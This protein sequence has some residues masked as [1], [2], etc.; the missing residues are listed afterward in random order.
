MCPCAGFVFALHDMP[1]QRL[2]EVIESMGAARI[3][4]LAELVQRRKEGKRSFGSFAITVDDGVGYNVRALAQLFL[5]RAWPATF[6]L[7]TQYLD[8]GEPM[9]FQWWRR[10]KPLLPHRKLELKSGALDLSRPGAIEALSRSMEQRWRRERPETHLPLISE[11]AD[12]AAREIGVARAELR[13]PAPIS[14][15]EVAELSR[16]DLIRFE[17]HGVSHTA[18]SALT[19]DELVFEMG[20]SQQLIEE[21]TGR[22]CR[23]LCYPFG[24][25]ASIGPLPPRIASRFYDSAVTME[26]GATNDA[27]PWLLPRI[28]LY[29][30]NSLLFARM[31]VLLKRGMSN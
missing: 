13:A 30:K 21:H 28:P 29:P 24:S 1:A 10:L 26:L 16:N 15:R 7:P 8:T 9:A 4:P 12:V 25:R 2:A 20:R 5:S 14:W 18:M 27:D 31:K 6:Y 3:V 11:L 23:H 19:E 22:P 17:S